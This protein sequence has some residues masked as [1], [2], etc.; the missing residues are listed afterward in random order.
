MI[1]AS[2]SD[3]RSRDQ[4]SQIA[5]FLTRREAIFPGLQSRLITIFGE[6]EQYTFV[7]LLWS[8]LVDT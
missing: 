4:C 6:R 2:G 5:Q 1:S 7:A 8:D 3:K